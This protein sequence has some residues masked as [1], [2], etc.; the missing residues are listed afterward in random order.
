MIVEKERLSNLFSYLFLFKDYCIL[1]PRST[2]SEG[3]PSF[4]L[5]KL[6][7]TDFIGPYI[8]PLYERF[9]LFLLIPIHRDPQAPGVLLAMFTSSC[10]HSIVSS[11][12]WS[13]KV[14]ESGSS[15]M[16]LCSHFILICIHFK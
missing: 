9:D 15:A 10:E 16:V 2:H 11:L 7:G 1:K 3:H 14:S 6:F 13:R 5:G 8:H 4:I 12:R